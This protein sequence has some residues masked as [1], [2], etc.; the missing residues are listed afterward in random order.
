MKKLQVDRFEEGFAVLV[1]DDGMPID[2]PRNHFGF[3]L[4]EG[5]I[6]AVEFDGKT[7][8]SAVFLEEET[9]AVKARIEALRRKL[10][11]KNKK[12]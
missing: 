12:Q 5:D 6:L 2:V 3:E 1:D 7:P 8:V 10:R 9:L 11:E 4:H